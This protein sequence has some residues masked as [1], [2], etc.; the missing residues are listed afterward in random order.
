MSACERLQEDLYFGLSPII[1]NAKPFIDAAAAAHCTVLLRG[2]TGTGKGMLARWIHEHS[3][4]NENAFVEINCSGLKGELLK[5]ELFG[6]SRGAFTGALNDRTGLIEEANGGTLFLDEIGDM[7]AG[8]QCE[9]L[10]AIEEK[11]FRRVGENKLRSSDFRL[12]C[13]TNRDLPVA[14]GSGDFRPDLFYRISTLSICLPSLRERMEDIA[15]LLHYMLTNMGYRHFPVSANVV[16]ALTRY[17]WP[18]NIRELR[19]AVERALLFAHGAPLAPEH[20]HGLDNA[21]AP[22]AYCGGMGMP[23]G[24]WDLETFERAHILRV[25]KHFEGNKQ[26]ACVALGISQTSMYRKLEKAWNESRGDML[27]AVK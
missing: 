2:E 6:H 8:V 24:S 7:D 14:M 15:G 23:S 18:G 4:R 27:F 13:A 3:P 25:L 22:S 10:K 21:P 26:K 9:L 1:G 16:D 5:S 19:N 17:H 12:L 11:T 20:F